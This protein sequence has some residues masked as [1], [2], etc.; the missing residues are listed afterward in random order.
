MKSTKIT[1]LQLE[2]STGNRCLPPRTLEAGSPAIYMYVYIY[3]YI[4]IYTYVHIYIYIYTYIHICVYIYAHVHIYIYIYI[5]I[6]VRPCRASDLCHGFPSQFFFPLI[7]A[8]WGLGF[9]DQEACP[10]GHPRGSKCRS[11]WSQMEHILPPMQPRHAAHAQAVRK[12]LLRVPF[13]PP[14]FSAKHIF[15]APKAG[16]GMPAQSYRVALK[17]N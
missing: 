12:L 13:R 15:P 6:R 8:S 7:C 3:I 16:Q 10:W 17:I 1:L 14:I 4:C 5:Y 11:Q 2:A 9:L